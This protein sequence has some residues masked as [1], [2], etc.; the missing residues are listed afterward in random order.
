[1]GD[2]NIRPEKI[3]SLILNFRPKLSVMPQIEHQPVE[4]RQSGVK[5]NYTS[6]F[7]LIIDLQLTKQDKQ[8]LQQ[9]LYIAFEKRSGRF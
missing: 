9:G 7:S 3:I 8:Y 1:M 6:D 5:K 4:I 2:R